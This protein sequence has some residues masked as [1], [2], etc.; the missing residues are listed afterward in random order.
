MGQSEIADIANEKCR[1]LPFY[2][3]LDGF[4]RC[5]SMEVNFITESM[6][7]AYVEVKKVVMKRKSLNR[8]ST[9]GKDFQNF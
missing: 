4:G 5:H 2:G 1:Y 7:R 8:G 3:S 6:V 9:E